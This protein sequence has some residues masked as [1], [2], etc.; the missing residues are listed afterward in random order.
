MILA[1]IIKKTE[2]EISCASA[3]NLSATIPNL[4]LELL[5]ISEQTLNTLVRFS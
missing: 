5:G 1:K 3:E 4:C 2:E